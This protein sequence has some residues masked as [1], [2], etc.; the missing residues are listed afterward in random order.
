[1][2]SRGGQS[3]AALERMLAA[4]EACLGLSKHLFILSVS[5]S[6]PSQNEASRKSRIYK[7]DQNLL[8][9]EHDCQLPAACAFGE[10]V[11]NPSSSIEGNEQSH[12]EKIYILNHVGLEN[13]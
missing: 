5:R 4:T 1:M 12:G 11:L 13:M 3:A 10:C 9:W 2:G 7:I 6:L 8:S